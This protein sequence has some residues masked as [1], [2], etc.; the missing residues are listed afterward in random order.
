[1][2]KYESISNRSQPGISPERIFQKKIECAL[3]DKDLL[4]MSEEELDS[5]CD[6]IFQDIPIP[7]VPQK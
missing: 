2:P 5:Q 1:M 3:G 6:D 4:G 7:F